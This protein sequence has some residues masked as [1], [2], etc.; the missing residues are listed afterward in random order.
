MK[1]EVAAASVG[2]G[3]GNSGSWP[4]AEAWLVLGPIQSTDILMG[5][6][7]KMLVGSW[8]EDFQLGTDFSLKSWWHMT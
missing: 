1:A 4:G 7:A 6:T 3:L 8:P 2:G 5:N